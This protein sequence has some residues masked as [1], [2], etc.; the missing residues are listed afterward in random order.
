MFLKRLE[1]I[2]FKSFANKSQLEFPGPRQTSDGRR[3]GISVI[4]GP[5]GSGKSNVADA[6]RWVLGE[7]SLKLLRGKKTEDVIF[8]GSDKK[9]RLGMAEVSIFLDNEDH[10]MDIDYPEVVITR[11]VHRDGTSEYLIN[12][13]TVLLQDILMLTAKAH[14][15]QK[16]YS[17]IGQGM[18]DAILN[19]TPFERKDFFDEAVGVKQY[20]IKREQSIH[21]LEHTWKNLKQAEVVLEEIE[22]R[23]RSLSRQVKRLERREQMEK[24]L[25]E[26]QRAY[27]GFLYHELQGRKSELQPR[28]MSLEKDFEKKARELS[29]IQ[30]QLNLLEKE[31]SR[32]EVFNVI[33]QRHQKIADQIS[34][35]KEQKIILENKME[36]ARHRQVSSIIPVRLEEV[37]ER[38]KGIYGLHQ[39]L[40]KKIISAQTL[41]DVN[42]L[43]TEAQK[44]N[45]SLNGLV[46][47]LEKP[48]IRTETNAAPDPALTQKVS[49]ITKQLE[50]LLEDLSQAR[51]ELNEFNQKEEQK[52]GKFFELQKKFQ[53]K[54]S[55]YN[56]ISQELSGV[57]VA[58]AKFETKMEDVTREITAELKDA[59]W[60]KHY[61]PKETVHTEETQKEIYHLKHQLELV[62]GI[63]PETVKEYNETNERY[64]FLSTQ[65]Q[66]LK[67]SL[68]SLRV[69][70]EELDETIHKQFHTAFRNINHDFQKYF[71]VL[72]EGGK[73]ELVLLRETEKEQK[74]E[75]KLEAAME[76]VELSEQE[77]EEDAVIQKMLKGS[78][79]KIIKGIDIVA[80]PP[81]KKLKSINMLSG[82]ERA[83]TSIALICAIISTNPSPFVVLDEVEAS[84]DEANSE[85]FASIIEQLSHKTQF[86]II[87]HNRA[88]MHRA[89]ILYGVTMGD[90][91]V[92]K[93][94][95]LQMQEAEGLVNR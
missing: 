87:T 12:K 15:G 35:L 38:L 42:A 17:V 82:G 92:S 79:E 37:L 29:E 73:S 57:R 28:Y 62:G 46:A 71:K 3:F 41:Q 86:V 39:A 78:S 16:S 2:G 80:T 32:T 45:E 75:K 90:D 48:K 18:I 27:Y 7:Q 14:F 68:E 81:G 65:C 85:R 31:D 40:V 61:R 50:S 74:E 52:K 6:I 13:R 34:S 60:V 44:I 83:L 67:K 21:K 69:I 93:L 77:S 10:G 49:E 26:K 55:D 63:D 36:L 1:L 94:L 89:L 20:Q 25:Q 30:N 95:S 33:Q 56:R 66:D 19:A 54:Q 58:L 76:G 47:E 72:F 9:A 59:E 91:G 43:K 53:E 22:P 84:L 11:R 88:T 51:A 8:S 24:E 4:V 70:I 64:E 5:N 23:L